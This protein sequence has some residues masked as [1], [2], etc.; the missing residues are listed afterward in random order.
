MPPGADVFAELWQLADAATLEVIDDMKNRRAK[1][2]AV[3]QE[4][5]AYCSDE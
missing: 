4:M 3:T 5:V 1:F 2:T